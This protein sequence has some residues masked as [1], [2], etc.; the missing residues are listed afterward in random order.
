MSLLESLIL[1]LVQGLTEFLPISS[2]G[3]LVLA[4]QV[5]KVTT[6]GATFEVFLHFG[7]LLAILLAFRED[8]KQMLLTVI[9]VTGSR[10]LKLAYSDDVY[11][12]LFVLILWSSIPAALVGFLFKDLLE[13]AFEEPILVSVMLLVTGMLLLLTRF[14]KSSSHGLG[15]KTSFLIGIA[16]AFAIIPGI[17]RSGATISTGLFWGVPREEA[18]RFSFLLAIPAILGATLLKT[19]ELIPSSPQLSDALQLGVGTV[20]AFVS[21][22]IA[23]KILLDIVRR[24]KLHRFAYYCFALGILGLI[25]LS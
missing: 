22:Y 7:T 11:F 4:E 17:S 21:G 14:V 20:T 19:K 9:R 16:Q 10:G 23:I 12:K 3:H 24:G 6:Q 13:S 15:I 2:S 5:L 8:I 18:A 1:G 25:A